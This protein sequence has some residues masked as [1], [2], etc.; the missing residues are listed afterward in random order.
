LIFKIGNGPE[1]WKNGGLATP[2]P[3]FQP[4]NLPFHHRILLV[5]EK[6]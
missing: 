1:G 3:A 2:E 5:I 4:S 6:L